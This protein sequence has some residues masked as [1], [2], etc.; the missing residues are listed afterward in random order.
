MYGNY[1]DATH[2]FR[3]VHYTE[4]TA[5][6]SDVVEFNIRTD[7]GELAPFVDTPTKLQYLDTTTTVSDISDSLAITISMIIRLIL[8]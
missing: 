4:A 1:G 3:H 7:T 5:F 6:N 8:F 2:E